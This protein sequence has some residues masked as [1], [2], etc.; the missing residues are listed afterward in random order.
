M[1]VGLM[2]ASCS[3]K[4][5]LLSLL[6]ENGFTSPQCVTTRESRGSDELWHLISIEKEHFHRLND[7]K[8]LCFIAETFGN[9]YACVDFPYKD[10]D[11]AVIVRPENV[12]ELHSMRG[13]V[14]HVQPFDNGYCEQLIKAKSRNNYQM[15]VSELVASPNVFEIAC[16]DIVFVNRYNE[17]SKK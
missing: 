8:R 9:Y 17:D 16:P 7:S 2:G 5:F 14:I 11:V 4:S 15:R 3:G 1:R 6:R 13:L 10:A 12:E